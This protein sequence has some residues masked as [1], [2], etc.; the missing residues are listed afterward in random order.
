[1]HIALILPLLSMGQNSYV[2]VRM[3]T[4]VIRIGEQVKL[5][6]EVSYTTKESVQ[7]PALSDTLNRHV[8]IV[9]DSG[10][11]TTQASNGL[12]R[13]V[14][15]LAITS[16]D[17]GFWAVPPFRFLVNGAPMETEALLLEVRTVP[18]DTALTL[19]GIHD[20]QV[21]PFSVQYWIRQHALWIVGGAALLAAIITMLYFL[22]R[23]KSPVQQRQAA[24]V[25]MP[26]HHRILA[27]LS[28]L[29]KQRLWQQGDHKSYHSRLTDLL[30]GYIEERFRIPA[31]ES[32]TDELVKELRISPLNGEQRMQLENML[33]LAD[34]VKFAKAV[35]SPQENERMM[36]EATRFVTETAQ[37]P[38]STDHA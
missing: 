32:T 15:T 20:I 12:M 10:I 21:L 13:Q 8:E 28:D 4:A 29:D 27:A 18:L 26:L 9:K 2:D 24:Q 5:H 19:R 38:M 33:R 30:R 1:M 23:K 3:D 6:L 22:L 36:T 37:R 35:P 31:M 11:D 25:M 16:F 7:W 17:S 14:R 34:M